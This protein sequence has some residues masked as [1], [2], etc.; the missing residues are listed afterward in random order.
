MCPQ[1][2]EAASS[3]RMLSVAHLNEQ[4]KQHSDIET[5][6]HALL[7]RGGEGAGVKSAGAQVSSLI[8]SVD[9]DADAISL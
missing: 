1:F 6:I 8:D 9:F 4:T 2:L 5:D 7:T 3:R